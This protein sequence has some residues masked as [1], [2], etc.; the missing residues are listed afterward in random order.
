MDEDTAQ[1]TPKGMGVGR[2]RFA[3]LCVCCVVVPLH[4]VVRGPMA[5]CSFCVCCVV[6]PL[7]LEVRR[8]MAICI[9]VCCHAHPLSQLSVR[10]YTNI[11][12]IPR[13]ASPHT[14]S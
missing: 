11:P 10:S 5:I 14:Q 9:Y 13:P 1:V 12:L 7:H 3:H 4:L 6:V 8:P 2:R